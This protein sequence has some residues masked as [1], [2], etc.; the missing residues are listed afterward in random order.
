MRKYYPLVFPAVAL[1]VVLFGLAGKR[2][3][4]VNWVRYYVALVLLCGLASGI[5]WW[6]VIHPFAKALRRVGLPWA[7]LI[8]AIPIILSVGAVLWFRDTIL[9]ID[10]GTNYLFIALSVIP[11]TLAMALYLSYREYLTWH[12]QAGV[13]ELTGSQAAGLL[14]EGIYSRIRHPRYVETMLWIIG[15][16]LFTNYLA[17]Y[18]AFCLMLPLIHAV[19]LLE[20]KELK[21]RFGQ[22]Y[23]EYCRRVPRYIPKIA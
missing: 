23:E 7:Y 5:V 20:E 6:L 17:V 14:T 3:L 12:I 1:L 13:P 16:A 15:Y 10:Y 9:A 21:A 4:W 22:A 19:V 8:V 18:L 2:N 11:F